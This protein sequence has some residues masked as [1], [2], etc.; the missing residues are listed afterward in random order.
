VTTF[1]DNLTDEEKEKLENAK[2]QAK[3]D[4]TKYG[5]KLPDIESEG[6]EDA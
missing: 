1:E 3:R 5:D 2:R 4:K 6:E